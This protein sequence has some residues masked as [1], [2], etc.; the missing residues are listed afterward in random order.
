MAVFNVATAAELGTAIGRAAGGDRIVL[1]AGEY[2]GLR[3]QNRAFA[4]NVTI[5]A[6]PGARVVF[7]GLNIQ[8]VSNL[9][10]AGIE[11][12]RPLR[13][14]EPDFF[15]IGAIRSSSNIRLDDVFLH[16]SL[17][18]TPWNDGRG[19]QINGSTNVTITGSRFVELNQAV[20][21]FKSANIVIR[22]NT[23]D[24]VRADGI[25]VASTDGIV[26]DGNR[27]TNMEPRPGDHADFIQFWNTNET[28][29]SSNATIKNNILWQDNPDDTVGTQGIWISDPLTFGYRNFLIQNNIIYSNNQFNGIGVRSTTD[30]QIIGNTVLSQSDD[31]RQLWI[32]LEN[33]TNTMV[34]ANV[35]DNILLTNMTRLVMG[36]NINFA[37]SPA[38]RANIPDL[39]APDGI[40]DLLYTG[41]GYQTPSA[42]PAAPV[43]SAIGSGLGSVLSRISGAGLTS[44]AVS[45]VPL[46]EVT[47]DVPAAAPE[48]LPALDTIFSTGAAMVPLAP[49]P[50]ADVFAPLLAPMPFACEPF[51]ALP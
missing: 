21:I 12:A 15:Q 29:G 37:V 9:S 40:T 35:T 31:S 7:D 44:A 11:I 23:F 26:I 43:S 48:P 47:G 42:T 30:L 22:N 4:S 28:K 1:A 25:T 34:A 16:G 32:R 20:S 10:L 39:A 2:G 5:A 38:L 24:E 51:V 17:D 36:P 6:Q 49:A 50:A 41:H 27:M 46:T 19:L 3:V 33:N 13:E 18:D 8:N 14:G 45:L